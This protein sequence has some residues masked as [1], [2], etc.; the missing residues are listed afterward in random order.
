MTIGEWLASAADRLASVGIESD[1][2]E[3]TLLLAAAFGK[4]RSWV[5]AHAGD[6]LEDASSIESLLA[7]RLTREPLAY[8]TGTREFFGREFRVGPGVLIPRQETETLVEACL[9]VGGR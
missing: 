5:L 7:R 1:R 6:P 8:I 4:D 3:A 9:A 2:L